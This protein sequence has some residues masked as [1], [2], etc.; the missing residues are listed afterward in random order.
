MNRDDNLQ[1]LFSKLAGHERDGV[2]A[3]E[4]L[5]R[6]QLRQPG[7]QRIAVAL[8]G[9]VIVLV[10]VTASLRHGFDIEAPKPA[11]TVLAPVPSIVDW[12]S[13]TAALLDMHDDPAEWELMPS[14]AT[15]NF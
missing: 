8:A 13:P 15:R 10:A 1:S 11:E 14:T 6:G 4:P 5:T 3:F 9:A 7:R 12:E 2:P